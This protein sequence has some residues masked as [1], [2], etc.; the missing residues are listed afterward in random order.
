MTDTALNFAET[1]Y[2][3]LGASCD[4]KKL[5]LSSSPVILGVTFNLE[6]FLLEIDAILEAGTL[7]P[8]TAGNLNGKLMFGSS[9]LWG[10]VGQGLFR[11]L[12]ERQYSRRIWLAIAGSSSRLSLHAPK[13]ADVM[14]CADGFAPDHRKAESGPD[15]VGAVMFDRRGDSPKQ[16]IT[17]VPE[18]IF[19]RWISWKTQIVLIEMIAPISAL[20]TF[21][22]SRSYN[23]LTKT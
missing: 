6:D 22:R 12:S 2:F 19:R 15:R 5:Q 4:Q 18:Y 21:S 9:Q 20:E 17:L 13:T 16:F 14:I 23:K 8:G 7:D 1:V 11:P 3:L 10:Q